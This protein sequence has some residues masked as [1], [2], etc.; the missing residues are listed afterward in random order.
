[1]GISE[2]YMINKT[3]FTSQDSFYSR[4][5]ALTKIDILWLLS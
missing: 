2:I 1:M 5:K 3:Y 4:T